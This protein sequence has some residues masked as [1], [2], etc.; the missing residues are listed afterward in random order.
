MSITIAKIINMFNVDPYETFKDFPEQRIISRSP[1][2]TID[3]AELSCSQLPIINTLVAKESKDIEW[4]NDEIKQEPRLEI[5]ESAY[6]QE[7]SSKAIINQANDSSILLQQLLCVLFHALIHRKRNSLIQEK[8]NSPK[9][10]STKLVQKKFTKNG[11]KI[12]TAFRVIKLNNNLD[13]SSS[14]DIVKF[15]LLVQ[16]VHQSYFRKVLHLLTLHLWQKIKPDSF[17]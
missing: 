13:D 1:S 17:N 15:E 4:R 2:K 11:N 7:V 12:Y 14:F 16:Y 6:Q 3:R 10:T 5:P 9:I 8:L